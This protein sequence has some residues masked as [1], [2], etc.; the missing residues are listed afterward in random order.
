MEESNLKYKLPISEILKNPNTFHFSSYIKDKIMSV[1]NKYQYHGYSTSPEYEK[2]YQ[3]MD[4]RKMNIN[5]KTFVNLTSEEL[6]KEYSKKY[7]YY[8]NGIKHLFFIS[9]IIIICSFIEIKYLTPSEANIAILILSCISITFCF[10]LLINLKGNVLIDIYGYVVFYLFS[11][12]ESLLFLCLFIFK[13]TNFIVIYRDLDA[14]SCPNRHKCPGNFLY[15]LLLII[16]LGILLLCLLYIK[17][18][19]ILFADGFDILILKHKTFFQKQIELNDNEL[20]DKKIEFVDDK[21]EG[22]NDSS[23]GLKNNENISID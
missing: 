1:K 16:N 2:E 14:G 17:F 18:N 10:L 8:N 7:N 15:L 19:Y 21:D 4:G 13:F 9:I 20:K 12:M 23:R 5:G 3:Q 22:F 11:M 6:Q